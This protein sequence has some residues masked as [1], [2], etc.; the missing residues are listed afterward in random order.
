MGKGW[1]RHPAADGIVRGGEEY[2]GQPGGALC[3][4]P[5]IFALFIFWER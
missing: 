4:M 2:S 1:E 5:Q 3:A